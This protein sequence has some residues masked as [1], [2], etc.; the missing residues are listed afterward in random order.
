MSILTDTD[1]KNILCYYESQLGD[2]KTLLIANGSDDCLTPMGYDLRVGG[3][4]KSFIS[5]PNL[6][7]IK[8]GKKVEIRPG[9][10]ALIGTLEQLKMPKDCSISALILSRVSQVSRGLSNISTK[11][12]PGWK[13][14]ELLIPVQNFSRDIIE[15]EYGEKFCTVVFFKNESPASPYKGG[16]REK[17]VKLLAQVSRESLRKDF[18]LGALSF[19]VIVTTFVIGYRFFGNTPGFGVTV[20][21][22]IALEKIATSLYARVIGRR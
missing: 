7:P 13:E 16:S 20:A 6:V 5:K 3:F 12:D 21:A 19:F 9:D 2:K 8:P 22:G 14:G 17:F 10:I 11:V 1:L 18:E 4:Y 15:L